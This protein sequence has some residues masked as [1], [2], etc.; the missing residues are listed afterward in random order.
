MWMVRTVGKRPNPRPCSEGRLE[1]VVDGHEKY[2]FGM[3]AFAGA[4]NEYE[5]GAV[6]P[7]PSTTVTHSLAVRAW[8]NC[9]SEGEGEHTTITSVAIDVIG[10]R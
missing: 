4:L 1:L 7:A 6:F 5:T 9:V 2:G 3:N 10:F 8:D